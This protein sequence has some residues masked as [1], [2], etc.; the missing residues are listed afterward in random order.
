MALLNLLEP[1][2]SHFEFT[3]SAA[4]RNQVYS[5][6]K[7]KQE[8]EE[9]AKAKDGGQAMTAS[10]LLN[11]IEPCGGHFEFIRSTVCS[12]Q[13]EAMA[14]AKEERKKSL[15]SMGKPV[16]ALALPKGSSLRRRAVRSSDD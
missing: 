6:N 10:Y 11:L 15:G 9:M 5:D 1:C 14:K 16:T 7:K 3:T 2:G 8:E 13:K 4:E 12:E